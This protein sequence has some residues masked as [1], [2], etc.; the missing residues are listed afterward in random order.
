MFC[1][2][3]EETLSNPVTTPIVYA[4]SGSSSTGQMANYIAL[5]L[6]RARVAKMSCI[7][8]VGGDLPAFVGF[9]TWGRPTVVIDGCHQQCAKKCLARH[10]VV[11]DRHYTLTDFGIA[12]RQNTDFDESEAAF[13][14]EH[15]R[16][17]LT[18]PARDLARRR[19]LTRSRTAEPSP[20]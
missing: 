8:G 13:I 12:K 17:A 11:P 3:E 16:I 19:S 4:C 6:D 2:R 10:G 15:I 5:C 1:D 18:P 7:A 20:R 9:A 14:F